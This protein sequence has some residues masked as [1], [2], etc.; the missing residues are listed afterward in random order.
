MPSDDESCQSPKLAFRSFFLNPHLGTLLHCLCWV[1]QKTDEGERGGN[2]GGEGG[3]DPRGERLRPERENPG[4]T[5]QG[6]M[7]EVGRGRDPEER[8]GESKVQRERERD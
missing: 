5:G 1:T 7:A 8:K 2:G 3:R 4:D 6:G